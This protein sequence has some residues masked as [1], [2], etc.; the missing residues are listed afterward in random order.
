[1]PFPG[2]MKRFDWVSGISW[3]M[4]TPPSRKRPRGAGVRITQARRVRERARIRPYA[5]DPSPRPRPRLCVSSR[6][7]GRTA[8]LHWAA[9]RA[10]DAVAIGTMIAIALLLWRVVLKV[11]GVLE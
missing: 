11:T 4:P 5:L 6:R 7:D 9:E 10:L 8:T 3:L 2:Q 1:M